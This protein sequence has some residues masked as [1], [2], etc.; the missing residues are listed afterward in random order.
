[1]SQLS[2]SELNNGL[3]HIHE[4]AFNA[5]VGYAAVVIACGSRDEKEGQKGIAHF[6]EHCLFKGTVK[7]RAHHIINRLETVGAEIDAYTTK[8]YTCIYT[9]FMNN[10]LERA[11][12][13]MSDILFHSQFPERELDRE[14]NVILDEIQ[15]Y[16]DNPSEQ[17]FEDFEDLIFKDHPLAGSILGSSKSVKGLNRS[18]LI[19]FHQKY[20]SPTNLLLS[21][22]VNVSD[23]KIARLAAKYFGEVRGSQKF[24]REK[25]SVYWKSIDKQLKKK[26]FQSHYI[27]GGKAYPIDHERRESLNLLNNITGGHSMNS[28]LN[29]VVREKQG[30]A[31]HIETGYA[32][33]SDTGLFYIYLGCD[34]KNIPRVETLIKRELKTL[35]EKKLSPVQLTN[36]KRQYQGQLSIAMESRANRVMQR[37][38]SMMTQG[39]IESLNDILKRVDGISAKDIQDTANEIFDLNN[40]S[41]LIYL[42]T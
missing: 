37:A 26:T 20:Y 11:L 29:L 25:K 18:A 9:V 39:E 19:D 3:I 27:Q 13:L 22:S 36:A 42:N 41:R 34:A 10:Y 21:T 4:P 2:L 24:E 40:F 1:M 23:K 35:K 32:P 31:Y 6:L 30:L 7:R 28:R 8:E 15:S 38:R 17:I 12:E 14:K 33:F 5:N 16:R